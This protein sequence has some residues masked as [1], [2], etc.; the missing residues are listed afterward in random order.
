MQI[1]IQTQNFS[2]SRALRN[3]VERRASFA[4]TCCEGHIKRVVVRLSDINGPRGGVDKC[5][6]LQV[7]LVSL[8]DV[9]VKDIEADM[10]AAI[11]RA[12]SR[13]G[14]TVTRKISRQQVLL[15]QSLPSELKIHRSV[16][17]EY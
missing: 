9:V 3:H 11:D 7:V 14:R 13:A 12:T 15:K 5:C 8:R 6:Q 1:D 2:L 10:Y 16:K 17:M 4:L